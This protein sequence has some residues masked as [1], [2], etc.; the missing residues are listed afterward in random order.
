MH[1]EPP[2]R[3]YLRLV[4]LLCSLCLPLYVLLHWFLFPLVF[5]PEDPS[6]IPNSIIPP[7]NQRPSGTP[8]ENNRVMLIRHW[9]MSKQGWFSSHPRTSSVLDCHATVCAC[10]CACTCN[11]LYR[12]EYILL[13]VHL[14]KRGSSPTH[15]TCWKF[16]VKMPFLWMKF[17]L[18]YAQVDR[19]ITQSHERENDLWGFT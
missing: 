15:R 16:A 5:T 6:E 11:P 1:S 13:S 4:G 17:I 7:A 8:L 14:Y 2:R 3:G 9:A 10:M 19:W 18:S 12:Q